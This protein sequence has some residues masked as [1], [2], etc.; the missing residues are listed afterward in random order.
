MQPAT[1]K[2]PFCVVPVRLLT[3]SFSPICPQPDGKSLEEELI[4]LADCDIPRQ[5]FKQDE[6][7]CLNLNITCPA[8]HDRESQIPVMVWIHG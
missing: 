2:S 5:V 7:D 3:C 6:F 4:G 1:G 8:G